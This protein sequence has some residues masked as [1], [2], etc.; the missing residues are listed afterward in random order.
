M[1]SDIAI[2]LDPERDLIR[3]SDP[4]DTHR[5]GL[6]ATKCSETRVLFSDQRE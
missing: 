1:K 3:V 5:R 4:R 6:R 2:R